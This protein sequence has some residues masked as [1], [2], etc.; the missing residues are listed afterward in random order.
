MTDL[1]PGWTSVR[2]GEVSLSVE[3]IEPKELGRPNFRYVDIGSIDGGR[4]LIANVESV[5]V[6]DA[7]SR[8][9]QLIKSGDTVFSTVRPYLKKSD[10]YLMNLT[11][12]LL[13]LDFACCGRTRV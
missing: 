4:Q 6:E 10:T 1:P 9:R 3:K 5:A 11:E 8:A 13:L 7:P 12:K 2:L